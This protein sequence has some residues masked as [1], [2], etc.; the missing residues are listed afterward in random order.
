[1]N[2]FDLEQNKLQNI[3]KQYQELLIEYEAKIEK[4][5]KDYKNDPFL[6]ANLLEQFY[7][8]LAQIQRHLQDPFFG[9]IDFTDST[10]KLKDVC[11]IGKV[12]IIDDEGKIITVDWRAPIASLYYDSNVGPTSYDSP[13]GIIKGNL[14]LKRQ[15]EIKN[16]ELLSYQDVNTVSNDELLK[17]YLSVNADNRLKNIVAT[18][19]SEQNQIIRKELRENNI[20]QG[21][22]GSGKTTVALHRIAYL[23]Y[24]EQKK[25]NENQFI[26]I[27]PNAYFMDYISSVLPDLDVNTVTQYTF[28]DIVNNY[29]NEKIKIADQN[30]RLEDILKGN[31][32]SKNISFKTTLK[33]KDAIEKF[34][35]NIEEN[36]VH[37]PLTFRGIEILDEKAIN[38]FLRKKNLGIL[39]RIKEFNKYCKKYIKENADE[40]KHQYWLK[41]REEFLKL[42]KDSIRK[43][44]ILDDTEEFNKEVL[45]ID[46]IVNEYFKEFSLKPMSLYK[47]FILNCE[48]YLG[49]K[50]C[51]IDDLKKTTIDSI[52]KKMLGYED[53][54]ALMYLNLLFNG[55]KDYDKFIHVVVDEAQDFG[56]FHFFVLKKL[57][58]NSTFSIFGD[59]A[60]SIYSYQCISNW[61][62]V[63]NEVFAN[64]CNLLAL[65]KS[66]RTTYEIMEG[67]NLIS[68]TFGFGEGK[69]VLR[70]GDKIETYEM[71]KEN[72]SMFIMKRL[73]DLI[74]EG[75]Q[76]IAII[77]KN[78]EETIKLA[79]IL[80]KS[81]IKINL[82]SSKNTKYDGGIC[83]VPSY[84]AKGLEF[85]AVIIYNVDDYDCKNEI[86]MKLLYVAM[87]RALHKLD[88][89]YHTSLIEP[90]NS[91]EKSNSLARK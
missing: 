39:E 48:K 71:T 54:P 3:R 74:N 9:R 34:V 65:E 13:S 70:H 60:Q 91:L 37:G 14:D 2:T 56:L 89:T 85:D 69:A 84:L 83:L 61:N 47:L 25:Y 36:I 41:F 30:S 82:I 58:K 18:I 68:K 11:Y 7:T 62:D 78:E 55:Y 57:F 76:S 86:D 66:Y 79:K 40:I 46:K 43:Q 44:E 1:M 12:G 8:K 28:L 19:Q 16:G 27:G 6:Q 67:A 77:C 33:Y 32:V 21:T 10:S 59:L 90:L 20:I 80:S 4:V 35:E 29:L 5:K 22:A 51:D 72:T 50:D 24:N 17:P 49:F 81:K 88:I 38:N 73:E 15:F 26:V 75:F 64:K 42:P 87:T 52:N 63:I 23:I 45:K 53:L 31:K